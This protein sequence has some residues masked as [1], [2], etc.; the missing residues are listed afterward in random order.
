MSYNSIGDI[1]SI[2]SLEIINMPRIARTLDLDNFNRLRS[3]GKSIQKIAEIIGWKTTTLFCACRRL[4]IDVSEK[5]KPPKYRLDIDMNPIIEAYQAGESLL[6]ICSRLNLSRPIIITRLQDAGIEIR[7][8]SIANMVSMAQMPKSVRQARAD[9]AHKARSGSKALHAELL[10]RASAQ[11]FIVGFGERE[12]IEYFRSKGINALGQ[13][14]CGKYCIDV[15]IGTIAVE[16][17]GSSITRLYDPVFLERSKYIRDSGYALV[18]IF[19][20]RP[21][22]FTARFDDIVAFLESAQSDPSINGKN[23]MVRCTSERFTRGHSE[24]GQFTCIPMPER[25]FYSVSEWD[26]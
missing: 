24:N 6:S 7:G 11:K 23:W 15:T 21:D 20:R 18:L 5:V 16:V 26:F 3:E 1:P 22:Q 8:Q 12:I 2:L 25:F 19:F 9:A 4:G 14:V 13:T 17:C 10:K